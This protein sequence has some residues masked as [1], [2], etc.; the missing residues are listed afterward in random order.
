MFIAETEP[1]FYSRVVIG[2][3]YLNRCHCLNIRIALRYQRDF[4]VLLFPFILLP[5]CLRH[6]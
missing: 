6:T 4:I 1:L 3:G 5:C 2:C